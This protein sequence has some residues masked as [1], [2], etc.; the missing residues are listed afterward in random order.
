MV[1]EN[2]VFSESRQINICMKTWLSQ[3]SLNVVPF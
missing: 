1:L 2:F 3:L